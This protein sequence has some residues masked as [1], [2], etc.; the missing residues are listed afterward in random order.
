MTRVLVVGGQDHPAP[1]NGQAGPAPLEQI[2][3][4]FGYRVKAY[5]VGN[6]AEFRWTLEFLPEVVRLPEFEGDQLL[7]HISI[8]GDRAGMQIGPDRAT[9]EQLVPVLSD[10]F[11][12]LAPYPEPVT[13]VLSARGA[14]EEVLT[15][16]VR[17]NADEVAHPPE[18]L[19]L[20][21][22]RGQRWVD[23]IFAW[24]HFFGEAT[25]I[26]FRGGGAMDPARVEALC[27]RIRQLGLG[28]L[29]YSHWPPAPHRL[30]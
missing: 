1:A 21:V 9:W 17:R 20:F 16:L 5:T 18:H 29:R 8:S 24:T 28:T 11:R 30:R 26:D 13:L 22:D 2:C 25:D 4:L 12:D 3:K 7:V 27:T 14:N 10:L 23:T 6:L 15:G 19:F